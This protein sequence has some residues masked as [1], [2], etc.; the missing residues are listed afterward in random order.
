MNNLPKGLNEAKILQLIKFIRKPIPLFEK[1]RNIYGKTFTL[2]LPGQPPYVVVSDP[3]DLKQVFTANM[4]KLNAGEINGSVLEPVLGNCSL[5]TI[6]GQKHFQH[7]KLILPHFQGSRMKVYGQIMAEISE[8]AISNWQV[9]SEFSLFDEA[10][11]ITFNIILTA[12][13]GMDEKSSRFAELDN[14]LHKLIYVIKKPFGLITLINKILHRN[15]GPLTPWSKIMKLRKQVDSYLIEEIEA[16]K[17]MDLSSR[18]DILSLLVQARNEDGSPM[19]NQEIRDEMI[20]LLIAGHETTATGI[21][22]AL[23]EILSNQEVLTKL[24]EELTTIVLKKEDLVPNLEKLVYLDAIIKEALRL[25]PVVPYIARITKEEFKIGDYTLPKGVVIVP[26]IYLAHR[27][28]QTW[29]NSEKFIPERFINSTEVPHTYLP[30]GGGMRRCIGA[31]FAQYEM[32]IVI[33]HILLGAELK[34]KNDYA[35]KLVRKGVVIAPSD[36]VPAI[37]RKLNPLPV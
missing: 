24:K 25:T 22:W 16:R 19:T 5:L 10:Q 7:R 1:C 14:T 17:K 35:P 6:D 21:A 13:F 28:S 11:K 4:N 12:I 9:G 34:L 30:F 26:S 3:D 27:D 8:K 2:R 18:I 37:V 36:G 32:K 31:A 23:Y 33:A 20:T 29:K 15:L